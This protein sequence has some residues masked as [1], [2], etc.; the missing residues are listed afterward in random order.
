MTINRI[1][2]NIKIYKNRDNAINILPDMLFKKSNHIQSLPPFSDINKHL[3]SECYIYWAD[4]GHNYHIGFNSTEELAEILIS[5]SDLI[6]K[7][8]QKEEELC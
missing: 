4:F 5:N 2:M 6:N 1:N 3:D 8:A 7:I